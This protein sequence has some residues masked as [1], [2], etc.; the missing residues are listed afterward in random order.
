MVGNLEPLK[1]YA[2]NITAVDGGGLSSYTLLN[3]TV[4]DVNDHRPKFVKTEYRF[5]ILERNYT[6]KKEKLGVLHAEDEDKGDNGVV[7]Y[8]LV[9]AV[10]AGTS[11]LSPPPF[12]HHRAIV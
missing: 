10:N 3:V 8:S 4:R 9:M 7:E 5:R 2:L 11:H 12:T 6:G 1:S